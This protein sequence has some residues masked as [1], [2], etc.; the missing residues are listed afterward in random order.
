MAASKSQTYSENKDTN[1]KESYACEMCD[2]VSKEKEVI[3]NHKQNMHEK[4]FSCNKC[5]FS[6]NEVEK[7]RSHKNSEHP[8]VIHQCE[9]CDF[10]TIHEN[11]LKKHTRINHS[12]DFQC[13]KCDYR[14]KG[15][16]D[17]T[18]HKKT[19]HIPVF[20]C[21]I[22]SYKAFNQADLN[23]HI[24]V[25]HQ[26]DN[27]QQSRY[28]NRTRKPTIIE[29]VP[30]KNRTEEQHNINVP[31]PESKPS[32]HHD[33]NNLNKPH[34]CGKCD[35]G[36]ERFTHKDELDLHMMFYHNVGSSQTQ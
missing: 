8:P 26:D 9:F 1:G 14:A 25:M 13:D 20:P 35:S 22:C 2:F 4:K 31:K 24:R 30:R 15:E 17:L 16:L 29:H 34:I 10:D 32:S 5:K 19:K 27:H 6:T 12:P 3:V 23:R 11:Q 7:L 28:F 36:A 21:Q 33:P 18:T